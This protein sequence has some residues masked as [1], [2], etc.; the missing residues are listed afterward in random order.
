MPSFIEDVPRGKTVLF[1]LLFSSMAA[2][3]DL[4]LALSSGIRCR[5][6]TLRRKGRPTNSA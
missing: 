6:E 4:K 3:T 5:L 2:P 1:F